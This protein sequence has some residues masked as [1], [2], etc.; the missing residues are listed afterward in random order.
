MLYCILIL[1]LLVM[2][3]IELFQTGIEYGHISAVTV[4]ATFRRLQLGKQLVT[5]LER[6]SRR[7]DCQLPQSMFILDGDATL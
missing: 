1:H 7:C 3:K 4:D 2:G 5:T 6:I